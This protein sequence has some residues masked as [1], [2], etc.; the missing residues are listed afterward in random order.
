MY[1]NFLSTYS[2]K[3]SCHTSTTLQTSI[4]RFVSDSWASCIPN[5]MAIFR[6]GPLNGAVECRW[7]WAKSQFTVIIWLSDRCCMCEQQLRQSTVQFT[8]QTATR[9]ESC[10][11][12][13]AAWTTTTKREEQKLILRSDKSE[14]KVTNNRRLCSTYIVLLKL[15]TVYWQTRSIARPLCDSRASRPTWNWGLD[16]KEIWRELQ[17]RGSWNKSSAGEKYLEYHG[18]NTAP[19]HQYD[20]N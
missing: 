17:N 14:A 3:K 6:R 20:M 12:Q 1:V 11:S 18:E 16:S 9:R 5:V 15:T 7:S 13:S 4:A 8:A 19:M 2:D 10:L